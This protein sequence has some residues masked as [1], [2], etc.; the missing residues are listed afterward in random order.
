MKKMALL[1]AATCAL[2]MTGCGVIPRSPALTA[3]LVPSMTSTEPG[4]IDNTVKPLKRGTASVRGIVLFANG[5]ASIAAAMKQ[6]GITKV[7]H[8][9]THVRTYFWMYT[10]YTTIVWGE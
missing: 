10:E 7:H 9:D 4:F 1:V 2:M 8:V 6:G 3:S 5:D